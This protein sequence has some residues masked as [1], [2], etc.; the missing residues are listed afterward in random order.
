MRETQFKVLVHLGQ[1]VDIN[2]LEKG[3]Y[4]TSRPTL[5][6]KDTTIDLI[7]EKGKDF[8]DMMGNHYLSDKYFESLKQC[9]LVDVSLVGM[10]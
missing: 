6:D 2:L 7:I 1:Y 8:K 5:Y 3:I 4:L 10:I 9:E